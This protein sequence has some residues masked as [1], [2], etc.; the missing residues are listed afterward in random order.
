MV[1]GKIQNKWILQFNINYMKVF[2]I[3]KLLIGQ[4]VKINNV[5]LLTSCV[6]FFARM[7]MF[8]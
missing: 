7:I 5:F 8:F 3:K 6:S 1:T 2:N 4:V